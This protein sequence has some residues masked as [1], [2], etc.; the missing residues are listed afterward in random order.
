METEIV[1]F[2]LFFSPAKL[3]DSPSHSIA[4]QAAPTTTPTTTTASNHQHNKKSSSLSLF[5]SFRA[6][7]N[8]EGKDCVSHNFN[9]DDGRKKKL[10]VSSNKFRN[11]IL[12]TS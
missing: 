12:C 3:L 6:I 10:F 4:R 5:H 1:N 9:K 7:N 8:L 11:F 2:S